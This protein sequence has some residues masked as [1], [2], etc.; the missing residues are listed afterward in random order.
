VSGRKEE[1]I[2]EMD[3][4]HR[5]KRIKRK[6]KKE[7]KRRREEEKYLRCSVPAVTAVHQHTIPGMQ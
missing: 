4:Y 1:N 2:E 3:R 7:K 5:K 6:K